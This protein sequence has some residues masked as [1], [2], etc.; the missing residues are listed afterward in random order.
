[1][2]NTYLLNERQAAEM[3]GCSVALT[4]KW[5]RLGEGPSYC[6]IGRLVRY[7]AEDINA[8]LEANRVTTGAAR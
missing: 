6:K 3:I 5:R 4:R 8:F 7:R 1:L 2:E